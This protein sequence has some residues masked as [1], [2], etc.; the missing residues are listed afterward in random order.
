MIS[1]QSVIIC[2]WYQVNQFTVIIY[3][4]YQVNQLK[5]TDDIRSI[6]KWNYLKRKWNYLN[7]KLNYL[8]LTSDQKTCLRK[9]NWNYFSHFS[10]FLME[11]LYPINWS[12]Y[13]QKRNLHFKASFYNYLSRL[14]NIMLIKYVKILNYLVDKKAYLCK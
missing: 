9:K 10:F 2:R 12:D 8:I 3:R 6:R 14:C 13:P 11:H 1:G 5:F 4:W 7:R